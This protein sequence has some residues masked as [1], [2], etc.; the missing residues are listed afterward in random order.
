MPTTNTEIKRFLGLLGYYR[1]LIPDF[2]RIT[3][4]L[5]Q[6]LK[7]GSKIVCDQNYI[8]CFE[9]CKTLLTNDPILQYPD[10]NKEFLLTTDASN[11]A[12]GAVLS[13]GLIGSDKPITS[14]TLHSNELNY[15]TIEKE[16]LAIIWACNYFRPYLFGR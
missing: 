13:Q 9:H 3:K 4:P 1:K 14:R 15:S 6:C 16:L 7:K 11:V 10:F 2:A 5:T 8:N 12:I